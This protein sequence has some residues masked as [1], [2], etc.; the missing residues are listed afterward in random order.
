MQGEPGID[1]PHT[2]YP[3]GRPAEFSAFKCIKYQIGGKVMRRWGS[4]HKIAPPETE[5][6][7]AIAQLLLPCPVGHHSV[8]ATV[9][10]T[11]CVIPRSES[12]TAR[13]MVGPSSG[14]EGYNDLKR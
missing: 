6:W 9:P 11:N 5:R 12:R 2:S 10:L 7:G 3:S 4:L 1:A 13:V 8:A 14:K